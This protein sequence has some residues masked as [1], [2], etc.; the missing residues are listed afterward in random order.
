MQYEREMGAG[1][2][3]LAPVLF[4]GRGGENVRG[5]GCGSGGVEDFVVAGVDGDVGAVSDEGN[6]V[7]D[8]VDVGGGGKP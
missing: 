1:E 8:E 5:A 2:I 3:L 4:L 6:G 7:R